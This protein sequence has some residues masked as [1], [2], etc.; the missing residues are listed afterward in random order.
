ML[1]SLHRDTDKNVIVGTV[2][3]RYNDLRFNDIPDI[4]IN[5]FQPGQCYSKMYATIPRFND[6]WYNDIPDIT[7][8]I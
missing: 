5:I 7:I 8:K 3:P 4:A 2:E 1:S 6:P